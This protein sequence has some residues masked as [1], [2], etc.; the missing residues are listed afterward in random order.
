MLMVAHE[1]KRIALASTFLQQYHKGGN[2]FRSHIVRVLGNEM[3]VSF[4]NVETKEHSK[5]VDA[6]T[7]TKQAK[8]FKQ[9]YACQLMAAVL[10]DR[11]GVLMLEFMQQGTETLKNCVGLTIQNKRPGHPHTAACTRALLEHFN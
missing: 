3:W 9:M 11:K 7:F 5:A 4:V 2:E 1:M 6:H 10:W 8:K